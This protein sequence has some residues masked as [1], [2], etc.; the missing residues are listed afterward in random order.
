[1]PRLAAI[2][3]AGISKASA[4]RAKS[5]YASPAPTAPQETPSTTWV[6]TAVISR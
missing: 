3:P 6:T 4:R 5:A 1:M 2:I